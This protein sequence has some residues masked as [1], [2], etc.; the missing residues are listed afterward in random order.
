MP[1]WQGVDAFND[2][3]SFVIDRTQGEFVQLTVKTRCM[4]D[5]NPVFRVFFNTSL[6][7]VIGGV[8][9]LHDPIGESLG[10]FDGLG[11]SLFAFVLNGHIIELGTKFEV[12]KQQ[13]AVALTFEFT[14]DLGVDRAVTRVRHS[15]GTGFEIVQLLHHLPANVLGYDVTL[16]TVHVHVVDVQAETIAVLHFPEKLIHEPLFQ[17]QDRHADVA[18]LVQGEIHLGELRL[19]CKTCGP[20]NLIV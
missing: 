14:D 5:W 4:W 11:P 8:D 19:S 20:G 13:S 3:V 9:N 10:A 18:G 12:L 1:Q 7:V 16:E 6:P 17:F 15:V 2:D